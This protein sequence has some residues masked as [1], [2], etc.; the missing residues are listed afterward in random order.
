MTN[1]S[2]TLK[3]G[4]ATD[5]PAKPAHLKRPLRKFV[6]STG[7]KLVRGI[8]GAQSRAS[9]IPDTPVLPEGAFPF[10]QVFEDNWLTIRD[11]AKAILAHRDA[12]PGFQEVSPDQ[13]RLAKGDNWKTHVLF[14]FGERLKTNTQ[15][16]PVTAGLLEQV[17]NLQTAMFSILAPGY[18]IPAHK[19]V[20]KGILRA[21]LGLII[22]ED[23]QKCRIRVDNNILPWREGESFVFDDTYEHEVW[24]ETDEERVI[25]LFDF[26]RP[27]RW[28]GRWLNSAFLRIM[29]MTAFYKDPR[30][31]LEGAEDRMEAA[32]QRA[33]QTIEK[34]SE[35]S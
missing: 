11:E 29:K 32:I 10:M 33:G 4:E 19:G 1:P 24:N 34:M 18:H 3:P 6:K 23:W 30:R 17:P 21:H 31:N 8:A 26:D 2:N 27:M 15:L 16:T 5:T 20:T 22:P 14:G 25:L 28:Y 13:Y 12:I 35:P 7:K 9:T